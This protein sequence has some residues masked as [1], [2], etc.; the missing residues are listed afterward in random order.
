[1]AKTQQTTTPAGKPKK[2]KVLPPGSDKF[3]R[4]PY[5]GLQKDAEGEPIPTLDVVPADFNTGKHQPLRRG[6]F[7]EDHVY[8]SWQ[9]DIAEARAARMRKKAE[10]A[11][12]LGNEDDR[13]CVEKGQRLVQQLENLRKTLAAKNINFD[14][15][16]AGT[17]NVDD[18]E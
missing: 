10:A 13:K 14:D 1:M 9:A 12:I 4:I 7:K 16:L 18:A 11:K 3:G 17:A 15:F 5:P 8:F 2:Q 6:D